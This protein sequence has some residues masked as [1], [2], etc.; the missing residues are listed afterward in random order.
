MRPILWLGLLFPASLFTLG[1][2]AA[3]PDSVSFELIDP[4]VNAT[5][6]DLN[7]LQKRDSCGPGIGSCPGSLCCSN[8]GWW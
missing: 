5:T 7:V 4:A 8:W 1:Q 2:A 3:L 6:E